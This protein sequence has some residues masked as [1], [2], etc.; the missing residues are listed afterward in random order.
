MDPLQDDQ[1]F[2]RAALHPA[3]R[4]ID[5][6]K[7]LAVLHRGDLA[8]REAFGENTVVARRVEPLAN[9]DAL[10][11]L[12][13][14]HQTLR[15]P[16]SFE[17]AVHSILLRKHARRECRVGNQHHQRSGGIRI[18]HFPD[19]A[20]RGHHRH[21]ALNS[22]AGSPVDEPDLR[23]GPRAVPDDARGNGFR[24]RSRLKHAQ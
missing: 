10:F 16:L 3:G 9:I 15:V 17:R 4:D 12:D 2:F 13:I 22:A 21:A 1:D 18:H 14:V 6:F 23:V 24:R 20:V 8:H 7:R 11:V 5:L 19:D